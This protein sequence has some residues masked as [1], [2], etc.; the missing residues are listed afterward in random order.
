MAEFVYIDNSNLFLGA[1]R[2]SAQFQPESEEPSKM[3]YHVSLQ[4]L[5]QFLVGSNPEGK[6]RFVLFGS[7][8]PTE[9]LFWEAM[10]RAGHET[11]VFNR[12]EGFGEKKVD[13]AL[14]AHMIKDAYTR[15]QRATDIITLVS[16]D[17]DFLPAVEMLIGD[18][19]HVDVCFWS[20]ASMQL[21]R[22]ASRFISLDEHLGL[23]G[24]KQIQ[25]FTKPTAGLTSLNVPQLQQLKLFNQLE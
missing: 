2:A 3:S 23:L 18:G 8:S 20:S 10:Q 7:R 21:Q 4:R 19:F 11:I 5:H 1:Y 14:V 16:G 6:G 24:Y 13:T 17:K 25:D 9:Q 22:K 12:M 15:V